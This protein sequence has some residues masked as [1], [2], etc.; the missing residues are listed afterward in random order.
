MC[1]QILYDVQ[2]KKWFSS[3]YLLNSMNLNS[4]NELKL[5]S[6]KKK[7]IKIKIKITE[8]N[9]LLNRNLITIKMNNYLINI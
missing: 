8:F 6:F 9:L 5:K 1:K 3:N 4:T 2:K 7:R